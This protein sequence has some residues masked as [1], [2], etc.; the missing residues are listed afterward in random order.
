VDNAAGNFLLQPE[1]SN[2]GSI[3]GN[4]I[5]LARE[6]VAILARD[7][8]RLGLLGPREF[9]K[10][11]SRHVAHCALLASQV[12]QTEPPESV[13]VNP[14]DQGDC[15]DIGSGAGL[16][17]IPL[18]IALPSRHFTLLEPM[19][20]RALWLQS[21]VEELGLSNVSV[22]RQRAEEHR[23]TYRVIT[24]RAVAPLRD[25]IKLAEPLLSPDSGSAE[26]FIKGKNAEAEIANSNKVIQKANLC[27]PEL[28][29]LGR[30]LG[31]EPLT[32]VRIMRKK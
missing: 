13:L 7:S 5:D 6:Y 31:A 17:G 27:E 19:E 32:V 26:L 3:F 2:L 30:E 25:L 21:A 12:S 15:L 10:I 29:I 4:R 11:W 9:P 28:L 23:T 22:V 14:G 24:A 16:P 8:E 20:R 18:A 1:P